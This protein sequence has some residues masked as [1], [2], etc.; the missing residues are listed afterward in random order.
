LFYSRR[1]DLVIVVVMS[2]HVAF[3]IIF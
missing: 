1:V 2:A 3:P